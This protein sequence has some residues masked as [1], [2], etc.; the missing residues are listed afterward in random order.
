MNIENLF[1]YC[2]DEI[3]SANKD[4][5]TFVVDG[6][7]SFGNSLYTIAINNSNNKIYSHS[8]Q[9]LSLIKHWYPHQ[10]LI[11]QTIVDK[12]KMIILNNQKNSDYINEIVI[13]FITSFSSGTVHGYSGIFYILNEY[14]NNL[15]A[16]KNYKILVYKDS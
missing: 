1:D 10:R 4:K 2:T 7:I 6:S 12:Y 15:D 13:P 8:N 14:I 3:Q 9:W 11:Y 16:Y 5:V